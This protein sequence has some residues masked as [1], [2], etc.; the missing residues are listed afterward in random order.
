MASSGATLQG[1][2]GHASD[3]GRVRRPPLGIGGYGISARLDTPP[4][5]GSYG[6]LD[7]THITPRN[8]DMTTGMLIVSTLLTGP[9]VGRILWRLRG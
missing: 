4:L 6:S 5:A 9:L 1:V 2:I 3:N 7:P 8:S